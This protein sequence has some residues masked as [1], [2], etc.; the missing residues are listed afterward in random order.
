MALLPP[1]PAQSPLDPWSGA[2]PTQEGA[3]RAP[4]RWS[5]SPSYIARVAILT[6]VYFG[7]AKLGLSLAVMHANVSL[8]W[9]P[10]GIA[11]A[12][13]LLF[14][15]RLWPGVALGAFLVNVSTAVSLA[16]AGGIAVGNTLEAVVGASLLRRVVRFRNSLGRLQDVLGLAILA[17]MLSTTVS[18]TIGVASLC[19]GGAAPWALSG[20]LWWQWWLGDAMGGLVVAPVLLTWGTA[21]RPGW[22]PRLSRDRSRC[23]WLCC[24]AR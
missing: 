16:T 23:P 24:G 20:S 13:L 3:A 21:P 19:L 15:S 1:K 11:L 5:L 10:T 17:A 7:A 2:R 12:A 4:A 18:A 6:I 22:A 14:G 8:V 9:P